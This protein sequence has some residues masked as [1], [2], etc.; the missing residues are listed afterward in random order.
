M[1]LEDDDDVAPPRSPRSARTTESPRPAA[2][3]AM[4]APLMPPPMTSRSTMARD[5]KPSPGLADGRPR[6]ACCSGL[7]GGFLKVVDLKDLDPRRASSC[8]VVRLHGLAG[9]ALLLLPAN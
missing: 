4:P 2:S 9:L 8:I 1:S 5:Y 7:A 6:S 3:R